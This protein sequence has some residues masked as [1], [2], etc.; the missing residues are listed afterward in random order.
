VGVVDL[1]FF[2]DHTL[3]QLKPQRQ[4]GLE[5]FEVFFLKLVHLPFLTVALKRRVVLVVKQVFFAH[6]GAGAEQDHAELFGEVINLG[7]ALLQT[8]AGGAHHLEFTLNHYVQVLAGLARLVDDLLAFECALGEEL[9]HFG[10]SFAGDGL[11][12]RYADQEVNYFVQL[13]VF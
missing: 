6:H 11:E 10:D 2:L 13:L 1:L 7:H 12:Q 5:Q 8:L 9:G 3:K 4:V